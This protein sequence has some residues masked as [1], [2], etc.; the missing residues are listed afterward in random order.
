MHHTPDTFPTP[1]RVKACLGSWPKHGDHCYKQFCINGGPQDEQPRGMDL[2]GGW[3]SQGVGEWVSGI[4]AIFTKQAHQLLLRLSIK[5][6]KIFK[7]CFY[8]YFMKGKK[9]S[10]Y[11]CQPLIL[12][13][14]WVVLWGRWRYTLV[15]WT[16][17]TTAKSC[18]S[19][20]ADSTSS[21]QAS[22]HP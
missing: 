6:G 21:K 12:P 5:V 14:I 2:A 19:S 15:T 7:G 18:H 13:L 1:H 11:P 8:L 20:I 4:G 10:K 22:G 16:S 3:E 9:T 17:Q